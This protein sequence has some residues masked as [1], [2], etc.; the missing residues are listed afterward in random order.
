M[1]LKSPT[2]GLHKNDAVKVLAYRNDDDND[3]KYTT[4]TPWSSPS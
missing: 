4:L 1:R 3:D 2:D